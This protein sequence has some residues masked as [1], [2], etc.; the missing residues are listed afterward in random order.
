[1]P[2]SLALT[3]GALAALSLALV[4]CDGGN[5]T[6]D[7]AIVGEDTRMPDAPA[8]APGP[9]PTIIYLAFD[10]VSMHTADPATTPIVGDAKLNTWPYLVADVVVPA[11]RADD[12]DRASK[13]TAIVGNVRTFLARWNVDVVTA[14]PAS[15]E[16]MMV[17]FGATGEIANYAATTLGTAELDCA[18]AY[19][20]DVGFVFEASDTPIRATNNALFAILQGAG[21]Y[22][23]DGDNNCACAAETC[24]TSLT[25]ICTVS[26]A[27]ATLE[28]LCSTGVPQDQ[29]KQLDDAF[30][31][32]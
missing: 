23:A 1:M 24:T 4:A 19:P 9:A 17:V 5:T 22:P 26:T 25:E 11:Y 13:I 3:R 29:R 20:H 6:P 18:N 12:P 10:G 7:A 15:G 32:R 8:D 14:R 21:V 16:Y 30:G 31:L 28:Y 2:T 27:A